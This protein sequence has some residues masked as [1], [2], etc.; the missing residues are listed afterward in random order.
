MQQRETREQT[1]RLL[2]IVRRLAKR[3]R[4]RGEY[5]S[6]T[7]RP[8]SPRPG[9]GEGGRWPEGIPSCWP[10]NGA[11]PPVGHENASPI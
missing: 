10:R 1:M 11:E 5:R 3:D 2:A 7:D 6:P 9:L 4:Y 8:G